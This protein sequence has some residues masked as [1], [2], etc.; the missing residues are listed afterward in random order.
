MIIAAKNSQQQQQQSF[1]SSTSSSHVMAAQKI[2]RA[3]E[4]LFLIDQMNMEIA[5]K[6]KEKRRSEA[7]YAEMLAAETRLRRLLEGAAA[8]TTTTNSIVVGGAKREGPLPLLQALYFPWWGMI[9]E[10]VK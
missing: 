7:E 10:I 3:E 4:A 9:Q 1:P 6:Q 8:D 5:R 2:S